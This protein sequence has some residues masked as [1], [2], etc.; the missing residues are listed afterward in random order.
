[1]PVITFEAAK[2]NKEQKKVTYTLSII[3]DYKNGAKYIGI[4]CIPFSCL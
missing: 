3:N 1:M 2:L 4:N